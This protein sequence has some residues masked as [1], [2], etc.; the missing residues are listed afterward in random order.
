VG[1][2]VLPNTP[3]YRLSSYQKHHEFYNGEIERRQRKSKKA[4]AWKIFDLHVLLIASKQK[5]KLSSVED[6]Q[7]TPDDYENEAERQL[8][9]EAAAHLPKRNRPN[10]S[11][12]DTSKPSAVF[13]PTQ[14][15]DWTL[16]IAVPGSFIAKYACPFLYG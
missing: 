13:K 9:A 15:R 1:I 14:P 11:E 4:C 16:S 6:E 10:D 12:L 5:R 7:R 8:R 3:T 2:C